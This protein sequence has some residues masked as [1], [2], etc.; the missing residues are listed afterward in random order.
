MQREIEYISGNS[1]LE[2]EPPVEIR[3]FSIYNINSF[4]VV[5]DICLD[6]SSSLVIEQFT[7][8]AVPVIKQMPQTD[9]V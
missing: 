2:N 3:Y 8:P 6:L 1:Y 7:V 5:F 9:L 4:S